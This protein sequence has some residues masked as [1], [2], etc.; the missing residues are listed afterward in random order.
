MQRRRSSR[1]PKQPLHAH[2][3]S[4][5]DLS[6]WRKGGRIDSE[7]SLQSHQSA[8][9]QQYDSQEESLEQALSYFEKVQD[10]VA[11]KKKKSVL[12]KHLDAVESTALKQGLPPEGFEILLNIVLS[13]KFADTV[14]TCLL[15]SL[16]PASVIPENS[17]V[18]AVSW[19]CV[20]KCSGNVQLLFLKWLITVFDFIDH[21]EQLHALYGFF[22]SFLQDE[23]LCP[24]VC[25]LLY[26][27]TRKE[28]VKP[29][30][31]RILLDLQARMGMQSHLQALLSLYKLFC[32]EQVTITLPGK[33]KTYFK[34]SEGPWKAAITAVRQRNKG[35][36]P[37]TQAVFLGTAQP[38]SR[39]RKWNAQLVI[40]ASSA[41]TNH[42]EENREKC[43]YPYSTNKSFPVE[44]LHTFP[45]LLQNIHHLEFPSQMGS[46]LTNPLLL[47]YMNCVKDETIYLRL[48]YWM[49]QMLQEE[50]T[51]CVV[52]NPC[53]EEFK[54]FLETIYKAECFLQE[55]FSACEEFLYKTLPLWDGFC[56]R[57][58]VLRLVSWIPL[59]SFSDI[60]S[61]LFDPLAQLFFTSSL[62]FKCSVLESLKELLQNWLNGNAIQVDSESSSLN[63]TL[64]GLVNVVAE[65]V[66]FV[67][68]ISTVAL[69]LENNS[70]LLLYFILDFYG[71]VCDIYLKYNVPLLIMPPAGIFYP[72][73]L[74][75]DSVNL[76]QLCYI[77]YRYRTNLVAAKENEL[78]KKK[79][80]QFKFS[81]KT[82]QEYNQYI[83]AMVGC[84]WTSSAFQ[85]DI[86]PQGLCMNDE[87][88][89]KTAVKEL[90]NSFNVVYHPAMMGFSVQFLQQICPDDTTF[91]FKVIKGKKWD[92]Y[93]EYLY[94]QGLKG[95]KVFIE[96]SISRV[97]RAFRSKA[98]DAEA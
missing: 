80:L 55:G 68:W 77:M 86:H 50:C 51:W 96:S 72:A 25:H 39:K 17:V 16:I 13:G 3:K 60:K 2:Q 35:S 73:L 34:N 6:A 83:I 81:N 78:C 48:Y 64:S 98:G 12:Q 90:K 52:D 41:N 36:S 4:Q 59:S 53:E 10:C 38:Q 8:N 23:K 45:Q 79:I 88:L 5:T 30:R 47:H 66:H 71:T 69:R 92:W 84:L 61:H 56:C 14:N 29:F 27:L 24:Y 91:N 89:S 31:I 44:Q 95:L 19:L 63:T 75:M 26:L 58:E 43:F 70:T 15:K 62:Y 57:S 74:S 32:P 54:S 20:S 22:F 87:L 42:L 28:H 9:D 37:L 7:K 1:T 21:K 82:Y 94:A 11:L 40:P 18:T 67:G 93:L 85:K 33:M 49:G 97:S 65:L 46:V 76:N